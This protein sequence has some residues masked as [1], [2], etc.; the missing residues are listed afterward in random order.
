MHTTA[1]GYAVMAAGQLDAGGIPHGRAF[2]FDVAFHGVREPD[3][4]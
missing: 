1:T 2:Q 4:P 3:Y